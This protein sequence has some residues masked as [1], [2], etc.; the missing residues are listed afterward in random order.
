MCA[1]DERGWE[2]TSR[3]KGR[4]GETELYYTVVLTQE[5]VRVVVD[6]AIKAKDI[7]ADYIEVEEEKE[8]P[9]ALTTERFHKQVTRQ[10][11]EG[12]HGWRSRCALRVRRILCPF[13][14]TLS[15][16]LRI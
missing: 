10:C 6:V 16:F 3:F 15:F 8:S 11:E 7:L 9:E 4:S 1:K 12:L 14:V 2:V 13:V 5:N